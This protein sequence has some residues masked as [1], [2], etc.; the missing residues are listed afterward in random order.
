MTCRTM[1]VVLGIAAMTIATDARAQ[2]PADLKVESDQTPATERDTDAAEVGFVAK[3]RRWA[4]EKRIA[5]R[6]APREGLYARFGGMV[7]G[8]GLALG[9][10]YRKYLFD[11][12]VFADVSAALS[13]KLY[14][15]VDAKARWARF[16][17]DRV[18]IWSEFR[19]RDYPQ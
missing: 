9:A 16:W 17:D 6:I 3:A 13:T 18:E 2:D 14:K 19:Y 7:T 4:E 10:G 11:E 8:S 15:A 1:A 5:D 12:R